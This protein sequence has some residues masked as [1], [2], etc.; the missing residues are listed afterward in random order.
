MYPQFDF[1]GVSFQINFAKNQTYPVSTATSSSFVQLLHAVLV[2]SPDKVLNYLM[3][4]Q[5]LS[6]SENRNAEVTPMISIDAHSVYH[7]GY[8]LF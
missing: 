1:F 2:K 7:F 4:V 8:P 3:F 5:A 6:E